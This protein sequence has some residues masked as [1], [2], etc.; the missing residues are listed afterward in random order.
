M[1]SFRNITTT[2]TIPFC[3]ASTLTCRVDA[4]QANV[5]ITHLTGIA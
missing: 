5:T 3:V 4:L 2:G 1:M